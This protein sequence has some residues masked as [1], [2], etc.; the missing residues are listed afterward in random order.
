MLAPFDAATATPLL[1]VKGVTLPEVPAG[2]GPAA[3]V[4]TTLKV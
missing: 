2:P 1:S 3:L 4:A